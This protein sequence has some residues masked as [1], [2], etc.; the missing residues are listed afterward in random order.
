[1]GKSVGQRQVHMHD[2][3]QAAILNFWTWSKHESRAVRCS[4]RRGDRRREGRSLCLDL[5][6]WDANQE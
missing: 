5:S 4:A 3:G 2:E 6:F 1:M